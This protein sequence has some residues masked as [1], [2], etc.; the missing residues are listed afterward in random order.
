MEPFKYYGELERVTKGEGKLHFSNDKKLDV[1]FEIAKRGEEKLFFNAICDGMDAFSTIELFEFGETITLTGYD[2]KGR[3]VEAT[4]L[5]IKDTKTNNNGNSTI[6]GYVRKCEIGQKIFDK[7]YEAHFHLI[8]FLFEGNETKVEKTEKGTKYSSPILQL[9]FP[10]FQC[11]I[12]KVEDF[13]IIKELLKRQGGVL[14][15]SFLKVDADTHD[16]FEFIHEKVRKLCQLLSVARSTFIIWSSCQIINPEGES[17]YELHGNA[18]TRSYHGNNLINIFPKQTLNFLDSSWTAY[19]QYGE[20]FQ[21]KRFLN[22]YFDTYV[23]SFIE[24][25]SLSIAV[26]VDFLCSSWALKEERHVFLDEKVFKKN[27]SKLE[28]GISTLLEILFDNLKDSYKKAML[29]KIVDFNNRPLDWKLKRFR[30]AFN[31]PILEKEIKR[32]IKI[33][34]SLAHRS[35]F[36]EDV[37]STEAYLFMRHFLDRLVLSVMGYEGEY[38]DMESRQRKILESN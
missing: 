28:K 27:L 10:E 8:N 17:V 13:K 2:S 15:T 31:C 1:T 34:N 18:I 35:L 26:L 20:I 37:D 22:G 24:S 14:K 19:D 23:D 5:L 4:E 25:R 12:E 3:Q 30:K 36:P 16:D 7:G 21:L 6:N 11:R 9:T 38:F 33:R 32:F 29:S